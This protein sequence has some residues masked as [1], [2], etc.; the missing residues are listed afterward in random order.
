MAA[1]GEIEAQQQISFLQGALSPLKQAFSHA[2]DGCCW[3]LV[4]LA[5]VPCLRPNSC[6]PILLIL[7]SFVPTNHI[8]SY[9]DSTNMLPSMYSPKLVSPRGFLLARKDKQHK[10]GEKALEEMSKR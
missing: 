7:R 3:L 9:I 6:K 2:S 1:V 4:T 10:K 5:P 8:L